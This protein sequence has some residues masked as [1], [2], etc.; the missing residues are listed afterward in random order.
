MY[1][2]A[3]ANVPGSYIARGMYCGIGLSMFK[4]GQACGECF[5]VSYSGVGGSRPGSAG[6]AIVQVTDL[7]PEQMTV[8]DC[9]EPAF[10]Q[11]SGQGIAEGLYPVTYEQVPC[12]NTPTTVIALTGTFAFFANILVAGGTT[13]VQAVNMTVGSRTFPL[14][15][16]APSAIWQSNLA[17]AS[18]G[19]V[20]FH[21]AYEDGT[22]KT[23]TNCFPGW[24]VAAGAQCS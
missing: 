10:K 14:A 20:T 5:N 2:D 11:I 6:Y 16:L 18:G 19:T 12:Q 4:G 22:F 9:A 24:P 15:R 17:G 8:F 21:I 7:N 23:L 1:T 13:G 3:V